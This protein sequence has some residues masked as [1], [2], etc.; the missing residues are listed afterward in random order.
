M[1]CDFEANSSHLVTFLVTRECRAG[2]A[3]EL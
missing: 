3:V 2:E 1:V